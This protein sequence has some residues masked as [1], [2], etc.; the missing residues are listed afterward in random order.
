[1]DDVAG[2]AL[3]HALR[4]SHPIG[5]GA[6]DAALALVTLAAVSV[7]SAAAP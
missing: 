2:V 1:M 4:A 3:A 5:E 7:S 6:S